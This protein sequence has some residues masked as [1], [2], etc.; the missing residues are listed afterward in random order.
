MG[1]FDTDKHDLIVAVLDH[2]DIRYRPSHLGWQKVSCP[3][4]FHARGDRNPSASVH[5]RYGKFH[6]HACGLHGDGF[7][8][9]L[10]VEGLQALDVLSMLGVE[11]GDGK[12]ESDWLL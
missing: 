2:L 1:R 10:E 6:C 5:L 9:M 4:E 3:S 7:D 12:E 8:L 11:A